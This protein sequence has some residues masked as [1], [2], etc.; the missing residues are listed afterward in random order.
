IGQVRETR[1]RLMGMMGELPV[2]AND[3][4]MRDQAGL[5]QWNTIS[6]ELSR[7]ALEVDSLQATINGLRRGLKD[8][9]QRGVTRKP[10][11]L[12]RFQT[13]LDN[14]E[15]DLKHYRDQ[16]ADLRRLI[17]IGRAQIG[18]GDAR[19]QNDASARTQFRDALE[20]EVALAQ[21][22]Q[23]NGD[24]QKYANAVSP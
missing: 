8:D 18:L 17:E 13:E 9:A 14:N 5:R 22:G 10:E 16:I 4:A 24:A 2:N 12:A 20:R 21:Q 1:R 19:Y 6:Q 23:A 7:R 3:F 11:D 15:R